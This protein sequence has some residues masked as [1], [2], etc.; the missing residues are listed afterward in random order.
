MAWSLRGEITGTNNYD[1]SV[2]GNQEDCNADDCCVYN[3]GLEE[4]Q[5]KAC[6]VLDGPDVCPGCNRCEDVGTPGYWGW[7]IDAEDRG[8][9]PWDIYVDGTIGLN[10][11]AGLTVPNGV[12]VYTGDLM[13]ETGP[14]HVYVYPG[15]KIYIYGF[16]NTPAPP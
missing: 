10:A 5:E 3:V 7:G 12:T 1:C 11:N 2:Y 15:G 14:T 9:L 4:C 8:S 13:L 16:G 6:S